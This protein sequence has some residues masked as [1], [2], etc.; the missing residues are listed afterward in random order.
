MAATP[1]PL[2]LT[3]FSTNAQQV[4]T[5]AQT[6]FA[7]STS[8]PNAYPV[9][10]KF[11]DKTS[12]SVNPATDVPA[13]KI[14]IPAAVWNGY[15]L[16]PGLAIND[17]TS[18]SFSTA[19]SVRCTV[20]D[21]DN[22]RVS[23]ATSPE[24][25]IQL[26]QNAAGS[27]SGNVSNVGI[28]ADGQLAQ[29]TGPTSIQ[30]VDI[31][32][33][34]NTAALTGDVT[35]PAGSSVTTLASIPTGITPALTGDVTKSTGGTTT[36]LANIPSGVPS[37]GSIIHTT[38][39]P[40]STPAAGK[41]TVYVDSTSKALSVKNEN[42]VISHT[43]Q[44][45]PAVSNSF[46][47]AIADD[48]S[49]SS[50]QPTFSN[51]TGSLSSSQMPA[52]TGDVTTNAGS[53]TTTLAN[54]P[55]ATP[56][57][58]SILHTNVAA[59]S[60]PASG[61][62][63]V[64]T[65]STD[66]RLHDK[67]DAGTI[68][69]TVVAD[70]GASNN[71][72]TAISAAGVISKAQPAF[73]N[74]SGN[75]NVNQMN[76]GTLASSTT[77]WRGDGTWTTPA[78]SGN[79]NNTGTPT[80][81]QLATWTNATT[82]QGVTALPAANMP[83]LTGDVTTSGATLTTVLANIPTAT[84]A[85]G[86]ILH[87]AVAA[88]STPAAGKASVYVDSTSKA[89][90]SK[91]DAGVIS[92]TVQTKAAVSNN[93]LTA[94]ADDGTVSAAQPAFSNISGSLSLSQ[95]PAVLT[96]TSDVLTSGNILTGN[97]GTDINDSGTS[98]A[99][100]V[101]NIPD[102][103][104][105]LAVNDSSIG[106]Q[107]ISYTSASA[108]SSVTSGSTATLVPGSIYY[109]DIGSNLTFAFSPAIT[110]AMAPTLVYAHFTAPVT[111][112]VPTLVRNADNGNITTVSVLAAQYALLQFSKS[113]AGNIRMLDNILQSDAFGTVTATFDGAGSSLT[114]DNTRVPYTVPYNAVI[115]GWNISVDAGTATF[116]VWK[117][118][119]GT[120]IPTIAD[121]IN[122]SGVSISTG[123]H[124]RSS[125]VSDFTTTTVTAGDQFIIA[126]TAVS[127]ATKAIFEVEVRKA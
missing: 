18:M 62:V 71:F 21:Q 49:V 13:Y 23:P 74:L 10:L 36:T 48:G 108:L 103:L 45:A 55:S 102:N 104:A 56:A 39:A 87:T 84:P 110:E 86:T 32:P 112:T 28:P 85:A 54:I 121:V 53:T 12:T 116:K 61:K 109:G 69:T 100:L 88:P 51:L 106:R 122:T 44:T 68:G 3:G 77:F 95:L 92:H 105:D 96:T 93:F 17:N 8:N 15:Q 91:N 67:N 6:I 38:I 16:V 40:P 126:M 22:D 58:G 117:K 33:T 127:G 120:A 89:L 14:T 7:Y 78:G 98:L 30:G 124:I 27:G 11:Y 97:G 52:L 90:A 57:S 43:V 34:A 66:K 50:A 65:D 114:T 63:S 2:E 119:D 70:T 79:V 75:I 113:G 64:Y 59:P 29:W 46:L 115:T 35:K 125:T 118:A 9:Y 94:I 42:G 26:D 101:A 25:N 80:S 99:T 82:V 4:I 60:S 83:A 72:L 81:G 1:I 76:S 107:K 20:M 31:L 47:T 19:I 37:A 73:S 24:L 5:G 123:T 41:G 111:L